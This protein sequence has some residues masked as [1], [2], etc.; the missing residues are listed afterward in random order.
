MILNFQS[1]FD[2]DI[3]NE[4]YKTSTL[5]HLKNLLVYF[6]EWYEEYLFKRQIYYS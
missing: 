3:L 1:D 6:D 5:F 2:A 4:Q